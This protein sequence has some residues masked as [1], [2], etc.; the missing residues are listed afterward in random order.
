MERK[1]WDYDDPARLIEQIA[2][3]SQ[4]GEGCALLAVVEDPSTEQRLTHVEQLPVDSRIEHYLQ[5][6]DL[7]HDTMQ[8]LPVPDFAGPDTRHGVMTVVVRPGLCVFGRHEQE[9]F[10]AWRYSNHGRGAFTSDLMLVTEH[11]WVDFM[12]DIGGYGPRMLPSAGDAVG[13]G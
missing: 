3:Q 10:M 8:E 11:G 2:D 1:P 13:V 6:R 9:W 7:I 12:T 5:V 4:L